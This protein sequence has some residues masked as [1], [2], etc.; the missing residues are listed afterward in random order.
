MSIC[1]KCHRPIKDPIRWGGFGPVCAKAVKPVPEVE[2]DLFGYDEQ[3]ASLAA[4]ARQD[5]FIDAKTAQVQ[6]EVD[7]EFKAA[8]ERWEARA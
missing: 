6:R 7:A 4:T 5:L 1:L 3:A 2:R 8:W